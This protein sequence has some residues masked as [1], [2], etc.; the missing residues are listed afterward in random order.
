LID[1]TDIEDTMDVEERDYD[2]DT[3]VG[4]QMDAF[5]TRYESLALTVN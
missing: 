2:F 1:S 5:K 4:N 3:S